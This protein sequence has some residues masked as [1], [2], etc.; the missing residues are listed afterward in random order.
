MRVEKLRLL[1]DAQIIKL[2]PHLGSAA[3]DAVLLKIFEGVAGNLSSK[4]AKKGSQLPKDLF[5][6]KHPVLEELCVRFCTQG[7]D[8]FERFWP[9]L[10]TI[11]SNDYKPEL[12]CAG[13]QMLTLRPERFLA[14]AGAFPKLF[15][16]TYKDIPQWGALVALSTVARNDSF[17]INP[18][19]DGFLCKVIELDRLGD[20]VKVARD[21]YVGC[22]EAH[23]LVE[24][25]GTAIDRERM[26][27]A[28]EGK[29]KL[30]TAKAA[31][32]VDAEAAHMELF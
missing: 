14:V 8:C 16:A 7:N 19:V 18:G 30:Y 31:L 25:F 12:F 4:L 2:L 26:F 3:T 22:G 20:S 1:E 17:E 32:D 6:E 29:V 9:E 5:D 27:D 13:V 21:L 15:N 28:L 10:K 24:T 11:I 23:A